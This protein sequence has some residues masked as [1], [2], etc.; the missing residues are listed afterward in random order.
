MSTTK[1]AVAFATGLVALALAPALPPAAAEGAGASFVVVAVVDTGVNPYHRA[2]AAATY[3]RNADAVAGNDVDFTAH[4][5]TY[6]PGFPAD[7]PSIGL[8]LNAATY[9]AA[10]AADEATWDAVEE[11]K[12]Y[13]IPGTKIIGAYDGTG[14][15]A[16]VGSAIEDVVPILD[17]NGH[18]T[19][20]ASLVAGH[21]QAYH[22][23]CR[24]CLLV[25]VEG[26][27]GL[28]WALSQPWIDMVSNS[29]G[30][31]ANVGVPTGGFLASSN[32][33][34]RLAAEKGKTVLFASGNGAEGAFTAP[35]ITYSSN[36]VGPAWNVRVGGHT[37]CNPSSNNNGNL[38]EAPIYPAGKPVDIS[39]PAGGWI[40]AAAYDH[41]AG[42]QDFSGTSAATPIAAGY[43]A[44]TL[45]TLRKAMG[46]TMTGQPA[47]RAKAVVAQGSAIT[48]TPFASVA[49]DG[50]VTR[51]ELW[52]VVYSSAA[53]PVN[54]TYYPGVPVKE[55]PAD[56]A[57]FGWGFANSRARDLATKVALGT[58]AAP[59]KPD[60]RR[61]WAVD[62]TIQEH[63]WGKW[64]RNGDGFRNNA[65]SYVP[66]LQKE[67]DAIL[68]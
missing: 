22:A 56:Y 23:L 60:E 34:G 59:D 61:L 43:F 9:N 51:E 45:L 15:F 20:T 35:T 10:R 32:D 12:L 5:S 28:E 25:I 8:T 62:K 40:P 6:I 30:T 46:D 27:G 26:T 17:E 1:L 66:E 41:L 63:L 11:R 53:Q 64:D 36:Y 13:W 58:A 2:F 14:S 33:P 68:G 19:A 3:P 47:T 57:I 67:I 39:G 7:A 21:T 52:S 38:C 48:G 4:P 37:S 29:W 49:V 44:S 55:Q 54:S 24:E 42:P 65:D 18:G 16:G 31:Q 50:I